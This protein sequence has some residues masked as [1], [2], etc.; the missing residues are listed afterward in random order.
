MR[1]LWTPFCIIPP[2]IPTQQGQLLHVYMIHIA[3]LTQ[4]LTLKKQ[5]S[6]CLLQLSQMCCLSTSTGFQI[7]GAKVSIVVKASTHNPDRGSS[8][9]DRSVDDDDEACL[10]RKTI[11][12]CL[13]RSA[14]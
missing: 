9:F 14:V 7:P 2:F 13:T 5:V 12:S 3:S 8:E 1:P 6:R 4:M 10:S 11:L